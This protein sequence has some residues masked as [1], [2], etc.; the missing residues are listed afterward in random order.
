MSKI[1]KQKKRSE[2]ADE[3]KWSIEVLVES[4]EVWK[5]DFETLNEKIDAFAKYKGKLAEKL[6][7][8][9][10]EQAEM[11]EEF[12]RLYVYANMKFHEDANESLYQGFSDMASGLDSRLMAAT[13][14]IEPEILAL[15]ENLIKSSKF[16]LFRHK[17]DNLLRQKAHILST[18]AEEILAKVNELAEAPDNIF[19]IL[20]SADI[21]FGAVTDEKGNTVELTHGRYSSLLLSSNREIRKNVWHNYYDSYWNLKNTL[22]ATYSA[23]VKKDVFFA[24]IRRHNSAMEE[25]LFY[26]N[27]PTSVYTNLIDTVHEFLPELHRYLRLRKK[28]LNLSEIRAYDLYTPIIKDLDYK[29]EYKDAVELTLKS[30]APLGE[31]YVKV[32][33]AGLLHEGWV[34]VYEN[35]GKQSGAYSWGAYGSFPYILLNY[36]NKLDDVFTIAHEL[37]HSMHSYYA[38]KTQPYVYG[39][40]SIFLAEIASTVNEALLMDYM[41]KEGETNMRAFLINEWLEHFRTTIFRQTLFAEFELKTHQMS[42]TGE[43][44]TLEVLNATYRSLN[45]K[46]YGAEVTLD[47]KLDLEWARISHF[48]SPFYVYQYATGYSAAMAFITRILSSPIE[49]EK[50]LGFLKAGSS[51]YPLEI[52]KNA[53]LNMFEPTPI[54]E[55]LNKF[56]EL[57]TEME[58]I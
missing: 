23:S 14:F 6:L 39:D 18:E 19:N 53:G 55:A 13:A 38:W 47:D 45:E 20:D 12:E 28:N 21:K 43:P 52:L 22:A 8:C 4:D 41:L 34:D 16:D 58:K 56:S 10:T 25:A 46:Y 1:I 3:Y 29:I 17:L 44:L 9:L 2:I 26:D 30:L 32:A 5:A 48:Y 42:E 24:K 40:Y 51:D 54:R 33:R 37:G 7:E 36:Q 57:I 27:I 11:S 49:V 50:Y 35:V 15:D 31:D